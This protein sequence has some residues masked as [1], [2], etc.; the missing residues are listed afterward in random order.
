MYSEQKKFFLEHNIPKNF[1]I[2]YPVKAFERILDD[3]GNIELEGTFYEIENTHNI[4]FEVFMYCMSNDKIGCT[5]FYLY[6]FFKH[7][8]DIYGDYDISL[9]DLSLETGV[10]SSTLDNY[11][12]ILKSY[13]MINFTHNQEFFAI[14]LKK[15]DRMANTYIVNDY[16]EFTDN[17]TA[18]EKIKIVKKHDYL[19]MI[20]EEE[21]IKKEVWGEKVDILLEDLPY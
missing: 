12:N 2:K 8:N 16:N 21:E 9:E 10:A 6:S 11:L 18:F 3:E 14:G 5:G 13:K 15:E 4:H 20:K 7:K 19:K 1:T 17:P